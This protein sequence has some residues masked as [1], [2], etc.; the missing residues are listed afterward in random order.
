SSFRT[1]SSQASLG[2][3]GDL[4]NRGEPNERHHSVLVST[5]RRVL[6]DLDSYCPS[7]TS[8]RW[9]LCLFHGFAN[10]CGDIACS[11]LG[12]GPNTGDRCRSGTGP[13]AVADHMKTRVP[14]S[15]VVKQSTYRPDRGTKT[16]A[17]NQ[18]IG[19]DVIQ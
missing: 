5:E 9:W 6:S 14:R 17:P 8:R 16:R 2:R 11:L 18:V 10:R 19:V 13:V 1:L 12:I 3:C 15:A 4:L 7:V